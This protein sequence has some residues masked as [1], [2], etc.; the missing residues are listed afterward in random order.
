MRRLSPTLLVLVVMLL[1]RAG[2]CGAAEIRDAAQKQYEYAYGLLYTLGIYYEAAIE[3]GKFV[4]DYPQH[5]LAGQAAYLRAKAFYEYGTSP[6]V[7]TAA[8]KA[9]ADFQRDYPTHPWVNLGSFLLG[10]IAMEEALE[11][12]RDIGAAERNKEPTAALKT[13]FE[14]ACRDAISNYQ[15]FVELTDLAKY[16]GAAQTE[17]ASRVVTAHYNTAQCLVALKRYE[18]AI[19]EYRRLTERGF[20]DYGP[21]EAQYMIGRCYFEWGR[22]QPP[23]QKR[24]KLERAMR[25]YKQVMFFGDAGRNE[26]S[27]DARLGEA[28]CLFELRKYSEC[29]KLLADNM[30]PR[31][32]GTSVRPSF[33]EEIYNAFKDNPNHIDERW[34]RSLLPEIYYLYGKCYFE[35]AKYEDALKY[36]ERV[37]NLA[38]DNPWRAEATRM[39]DECRK[40]MEVA[41]K[42][43]TEAD[44]LKAYQVAVN[45]FLTGRREEAVEEL[46]RIWLQFPGVRTWSG[47]D[48]L[49]YYWGK[50]LYYSGDDGRL[51]EAAA[52]FN[53]LAKIGN[54]QNQ[55]QDDKNRTVSVVGEASYSEGISYWRLG[56]EMQSGPE[57]D[58]ITEAAILAFER[59]AARNPEHPE[60]PETLL[61]VGQFYLGRKEYVKAGLAYRQMVQAYPQHDNAPTALLNLCYVYN[62]LGQLND[63]I[64]AGDVFEKYF[65]QRADVVR[66]IEL[67]G[68][69]WFKQAQ[70]ATDEDQAKGF[71]A[72]AAA[73]YGKL[74][75]E[76]YGWL[77]DVE[78]DEYAALFANALFYAGYSYEKIG[79]TAN[80]ITSY[81][82]FVGS[83]PEDNAHLNEGRLFCARLYLADGKFGDA[84]DV[85]RP[86]AEKL[87]KPQEMA[88]LGMATLVS[89]LVKQ[90]GAEP[91]PAKKKELTDEAAARAE[92]FYVVYAHTPV[93]HEAFL[94]IA[95]AFEQAELYDQ[96]L[97]AYK[98]LRLNQRLNV[99]EKGISADEKQKRLGAYAQLLFTAGD[100]CGRAGDALFA[101]GGD[102]TALDTATGD[103]LTEHL[104]WAKQLVGAGKIPA[105]YVE[106]NFRIA[107]IYKR[108]K[109]PDKAAA[110]LNKILAVVPVI[111]PRFLKAYYERGN[112]WLECGDPNRSIAS[113]GFVIR[114]ADPENPERDKYIALSYYQSG[115]A[116][117][118]LKDMAKS[119]ASFETLIKKFGNS[120]G[121][122]IEGIVAKARE[123]LETIKQEESGAGTE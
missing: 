62:K 47:R 71:Y 122:E 90:A 73:E 32:A 98:A 5:E 53:Y 63:V 115:V 102:T 8:R 50:G 20:L 82:A 10:E 99:A 44:A 7:R 43:N 2:A 70:D 67:K 103:F 66:A 120:Q 17:M 25:E 29:R 89:A 65:P 4:K 92:R 35:E 30:R 58:A 104:T 109:D 108:A 23:D 1:A 72:K 51:L 119:K 6:N 83:A 86:L 61:N 56:K 49:L 28:W 15:K 22:N 26:F 84:V 80:A 78:K 94:T 76:Q 87:E 68:A 69:A 46:E 111:E 95:D 18:E 112:V 27:D 81:R 36:F 48:F 9:V 11:L 57:K 59:L 41:I 117:F 114:F 75:I 40:R 64:W 101:R 31:Q 100:A 19:A 38:G 106:V 116:Y 97:A 12:E 42:L 24:E 60:A 3:F 118:G 88:H 13:R 45:K 34:V 14:A 21:E 85:L 123:Q 39:Y 93:H 91:D 121:K 110:A 107:A 16:Q 74:K 113:Y 54:P 37:M 79:D 33:F 96:M 105:N 77:T 52:V 55:V